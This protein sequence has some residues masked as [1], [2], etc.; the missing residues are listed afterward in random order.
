MDELMFIQCLEYNYVSKSLKI[1]F[2]RV[3]PKKVNE[4]LKRCEKKASTVS[5]INAKDNI[6]INTLH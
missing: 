5:V 2:G 1:I 3:L 6:I 4:K